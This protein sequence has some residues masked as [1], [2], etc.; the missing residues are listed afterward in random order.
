MNEFLSNSK[1]INALKI[2]GF[3]GNFFSVLILYLEN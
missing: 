3:Q 2:E 1:T